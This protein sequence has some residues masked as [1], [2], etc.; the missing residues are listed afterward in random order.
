MLKIFNPAIK[1]LTAIKEHFKLASNGKE[2]ITIVLWVW[3]GLA[4]LTSFALNKLAIAI[5]FKIIIWLLAILM[6]AY[7]SW[8]IYI[9][10]KC[11]PKKPPLTNEE[12]EQI[13]KDRVNRFFRKLLLKESLTNASP[14]TV[15][16]VIDLYVIIYFFE[17]FIT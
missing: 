9:I 1:L 15:G 10:R 8:H 16:I 17:Y 2:D 13:K 4:Y 7:F 14:S 5:G 6:I 11:T 3:G 12:K